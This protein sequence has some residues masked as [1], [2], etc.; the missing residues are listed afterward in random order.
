MRGPAMKTMWPTEH[1]TSSRPLRHTGEQLWIDHHR[2]LT[3]RFGLFEH[4]R[5]DVPPVS[6]GYTTD[7]NARALAVLGEAGLGETGEAARYLRF[8]LWAGFPASPAQTNRAGNAAGA[9]YP[10]AGARSGSADHRFVGAGRTGIW[11]HAFRLLALGPGQPG[12][13]HLHPRRP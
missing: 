3:G 10:I 13:R 5:Q 12:G 8:V 7:D 2:A 6:S 4:A 11:R 1:A 9:A